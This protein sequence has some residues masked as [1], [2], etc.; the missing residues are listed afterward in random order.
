M[1]TTD[2]AD[3]SRQQ[4]LIMA[5]AMEMSFLLSGYR[6]RGV[7]SAIIAPV[8]GVVAGLV[9]S[10]VRFGYEPGAVSGLWQSWRAWLAAR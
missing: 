6:T 2:L 10:M 1:L 3:E 7:L 5:G 4:V 8:A 9:V